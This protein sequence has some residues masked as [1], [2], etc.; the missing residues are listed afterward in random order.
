MLYHLF[1]VHSRIHDYLKQIITMHH[2]FIF[3]F[4]FF[5]FHLFPVICQFQSHSYLC[6]ALIFLSLLIACDPFSLINSQFRMQSE[7]IVKLK[8]LER[9]MKESETTVKKYEDDY[10]SCSVQKARTN[11]RNTVIKFY[12]IRLK[13]SRR[14][15]DD[16]YRNVSWAL[17]V[18]SPSDYHLLADIDG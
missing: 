4:Y 16:N 13:F 15:H 17:L 7:L 1:I 11:G 9:V 14:G 6:L 10:D 8:N 3:L 12:S 2:V 18:L 5:P